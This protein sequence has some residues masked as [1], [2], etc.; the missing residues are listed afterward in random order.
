[1][2]MSSFRVDLTL[3]VTSDVTLFGNKTMEKQTGLWMDA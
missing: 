1:M 3:I 2:K